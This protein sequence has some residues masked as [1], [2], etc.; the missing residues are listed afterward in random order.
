MPRIVFKAKSVFLLEYKLENKLLKRW[1]EIIQTLSSEGILN[2][3][4]N[5][6]VWYTINT[7]SIAFHIGE[8][9]H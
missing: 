1:N 3:K 9:F 8:K 2:L 6:T 4:K 7:P 5:C